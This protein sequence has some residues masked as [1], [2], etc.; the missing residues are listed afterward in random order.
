VARKLWHIDTHGYDR[1][2]AVGPA[3]L[4][5]NHISFLDSAFLMLTVPR[6]ISFVGKAE[7]MDSWKTKYLFPAMG[8]IPIDRTGGESSQSALDVVARVLGRGEFIG[9]FPEGTRSRD[10]ALHKG[11][12]GAARLALQ[13]GCPIYP[14]GIVGTDSIQPPGA[15]VPKL[16]QRCAITIGR[17]VP[18]ERY[19]ARRQPHAPGV[20]FHDRRGHV[21]D[22][23]VDRPPVPQ[24]LRRGAPEGLHEHPPTAHPAKLPTTRPS[25]PDGR[26][27]PRGVTSGVGRRRHFAGAEATTSFSPRYV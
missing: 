7:Y 4:C 24:L 8:M 21:R 12:T 14:V 18:P 13:V 10:G 22:P 1:L 15:K 20:A 2:P 26:P 17:P 19:E 6:N 11:R 27:G 3:I 5:P 16:F 23:R 9:M 25:Q